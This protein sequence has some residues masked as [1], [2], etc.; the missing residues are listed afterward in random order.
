MHRPLENTTGTKQLKEQTRPLNS[1]QNNLQ[2][3]ILAYTKP[4]AETWVLT[5]LT[6]NS[7]ILKPK[8]LNLKP[9]ILNL[10]PKILNL[11]P[12]ILNLKPKILNPK[13]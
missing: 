12:K 3:H 9:K 1:H 7:K 4:L 6:L 13:P 2:Q 11:K 10:K 5:P 8:T